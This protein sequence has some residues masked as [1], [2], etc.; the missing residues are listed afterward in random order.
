MKDEKDEQFTEQF[1]NNVPE[2]LHC[3]NSAISYMQCAPT[4]LFSLE[5]WVLLWENKFDDETNR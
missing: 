4:L 3:V 2:E 5:K 1:S